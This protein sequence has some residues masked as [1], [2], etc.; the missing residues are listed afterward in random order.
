MKKITGRTTLYEKVVEQIKLLIIQGVY[1]KGDL[2]PGE[3]SLAKEMGVSRITIRE[4]LRL[5]NEAGIIKTIHGKGSIVKVGNSELLQH[6]AYDQFLQNF[7]SSTRIRLMMEPEFSREAAR[8]ATDIDLENIKNCLDSDD[9]NAEER[10]H[11]EIIRSLHE[12]LLLNWLD[13][14]F[15]LETELSLSWLVMPAGQK[16]SGE[17]IK[18]QHTK[19]YNAIARHDTEFAYFYMKEH[20]LYVKETYENFFHLIL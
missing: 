13:E 9:D 17:Q 11:R 1:Q 2:L 5:L 10:F 18:E 3:L 19:I 8:C 15:V 4:A 20:L 12:P 16:E 7:Q 6:G 14:L